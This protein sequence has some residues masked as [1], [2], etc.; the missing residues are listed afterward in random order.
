[1]S[2]KIP[3]EYTGTNL[4][5]QISSEEELA[6][7]FANFIIRLEKIEIELNNLISSEKPPLFPVSLL[8]QEDGSIIVKYMDKMDLEIH[9]ITIE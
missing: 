8:S 4:H 9:E 3:D 1:M 6:W 5:L 7:Q 2:L